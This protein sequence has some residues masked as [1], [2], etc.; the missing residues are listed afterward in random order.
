MGLITRIILL[1]LFAVA[2]IGF[3]IIWNAAENKFTSAAEYCEVQNDGSVG[4]SIS[5]GIT[6]FTEEAGEIT[7]YRMIKF[8]D[9]WRLVK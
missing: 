8:K 1:T 7:E 3:I 9:E 5:Q 4:G 2:I 6:C